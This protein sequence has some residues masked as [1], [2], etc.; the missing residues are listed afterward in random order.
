MRANNHRGLS[1]LGDRWGGE[2]SPEGFELQ[3]AQ[4]ANEIAPG[5]VDYAQQIKTV[6][7]SLIEAI[8]QARNTLAMSDAQ[9]QLL[10]VQIQRAQAGLPP[11]NTAQYTGGGSPLN[12]Q[13]SVQTLL[14]I[15]L[16]VFAVMA[17]TKK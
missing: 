6:G 5:I 16:G 11:I 4:A 7:M 15:G 1:G 12:Q 2:T 17:L 3:Y 8:S 9:R 14:L 13:I 10:D